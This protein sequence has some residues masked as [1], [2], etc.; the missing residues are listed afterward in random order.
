MKSINISKQKK[1]AVGVV[2][3][4]LYGEYRRSQLRK[5]GVFDIV[6]VCDS[7][8]KSL[9]GAAKVE[10]ASAYL[11]YDEMLRHPGLEA[12]VICTGFASH[13][14]HALAAMKKGLHIFIEQPLCASVEEALALR[15]A[16][17][18]TGVVIGVGLKDCS[19][20]SHLV[21]AQQSIRDGK[22]GI[23]TAVE[24]NVSH[25]GGLLVAKRDE[26]WRTE[27]PGG[28]LFL[29]GNIALHALRFL[30]GE[31][32]EVIAMMRYDVNPATE[33]ADAANVLLRYRS[34][35]IGTLN[36]YHTTAYCY[37][38]RI[39]GTKGNLYF[40]TR[41]R[42]AWFQPRY[43]GKEEPRE[44]LQLPQIPRESDSDLLSWY[45]GIF[46]GTSVYPS[47][48]DGIAAIMAV[49]AAEDSAKAKKAVQL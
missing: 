4:D 23:V 20:S 3:I 8:P 6:A 42:K 10:R 16:Q 30:F 48:E 17:Q 21:L 33:T 2:G 26:K 49:F 11:D 43:E 37:E 31:V 27:N 34:G 46:Q 29:Q 32:E 13:A 5:V 19:R 24:M 35:L 36:C 1:L 15:K 39:F 47:L 25:S 40:E 7:D 41:T 45:N 22:L 12:V 44:E 14:K 18:E 9:E 28:M 38:L